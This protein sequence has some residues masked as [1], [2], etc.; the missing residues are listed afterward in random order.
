MARLKR[1]NLSS[2]YRAPVDI[3]SSSSSSVSPAIKNLVEL[4]AEESS[5]CET[6]REVEILDPAL[7]YT[8]SRITN[9]RLKKEK[10]K[11]STI[12]KCRTCNRS[13]PTRR[14]LLHHQRL[15][16][17]QKVVAKIRRDSTLFRCD[18]CDQTF[19]SQNNLDTHKVSRRHKRRVRRKSEE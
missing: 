18:A 10:R 15:G 11:P 9:K 12:V 8:L 4:E 1:P 17:H 14:Q 16:K 13:F 7:D 19:T 2:S 5:S 6:S 3:E